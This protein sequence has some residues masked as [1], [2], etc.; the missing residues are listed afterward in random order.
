MKINKN[1]L[2]DKF[3]NILLKNNAWTFANNLSNFKNGLD[4]FKFEIYD[5]YFKPLSSTMLIS[6]NIAP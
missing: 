4:Y 6:F 3:K 5:K 2:L 1:I